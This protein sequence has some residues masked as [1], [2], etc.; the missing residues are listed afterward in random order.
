MITRT[1]VRDDIVEARIKAIDNYL[2]KNNLRWRQERLLNG[3]CRWRQW[4]WEKHNEVDRFKNWPLE[5]ML[6]SLNEEM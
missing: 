1:R 3:N 4:N 6:D 5:R 2:E